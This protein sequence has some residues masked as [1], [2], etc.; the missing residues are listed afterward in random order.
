[1]FTSEYDLTIEQTT[2]EITREWKSKQVKDREQRR[3]RA[4]PRE[5]GRFGHQWNTILN[6]NHLYKALKSDLRKRYGKYIRNFCPYNINMLKSLL[7]YESYIY[8]TNGQY[9]LIRTDINFTLDLYDKGQVGTL[10]NMTEEE[11]KE[12]EN[13]GQ[14]SIDDTEREV[15]VEYLKTIK[16]RKVF[17][18]FMLTELAGHCWNMEIGKKHKRWHLHLWWFIDAGKIRDVKTKRYLDVWLKEKIQYLEHFLLECEEVLKNKKIHRVC[19]RNKIFNINVC[20][21][22]YGN[23]YVDGTI[24]VYSANTLSKRNIYRE[25]LMYGCKEV[26]ETGRFRRRNKKVT[27]HGRGKIDMDT[28]LFRGF[29]PGELGKI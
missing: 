24:V 6:H 26:G 21:C 10:L 17:D 15:L 1:M 28:W 23:A 3:I 18:V 22:D 20:Y 4:K 12:R 8:N 25:W 27:L 13:N 29:D 9:C 16:D 19:N 7:D 2:E 14:F 11:I 5:Y